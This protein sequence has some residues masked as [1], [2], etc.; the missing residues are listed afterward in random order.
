MSQELINRDIAASLQ[1]APRAVGPQMETQARAWD[2]LR[3]LMS[4]G[5][6]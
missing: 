2:R 4:P 1:L 5:S 6:P 3:A